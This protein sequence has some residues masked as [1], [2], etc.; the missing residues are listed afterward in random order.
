MKFGGLKQNDLILTKR[1]ISVIV[2]VLIKLKY[3]AINKIN[4]FIKRKTRKKKEKKEKKREMLRRFFTIKP[5]YKVVT[6]YYR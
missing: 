4:F 3:Q 5:M 2:I 1:V 6:G